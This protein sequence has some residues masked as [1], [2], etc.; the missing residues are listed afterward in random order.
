MNAFK[1]F[2]ISPGAEVEYM[3]WFDSEKIRTVTNNLWIPEL[4]K[5]TEIV[6]F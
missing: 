6:T 5:M 3:W 1:H 4:Q 2:K